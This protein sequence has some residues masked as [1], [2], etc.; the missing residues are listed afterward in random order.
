M[1]FHTLF[2]HSQNPELSQ[3]HSFIV[4]KP[5]IELENVDVVIDG[6]SI[7]QNASW[8]LHSG[9]NWAFVG[10]NGAGKSTLL[11]L[12][13]G[14]IWPL[15][16][17][18]SRIYRF[19]NIETSS[20]LRARENIA[21]VSGAQHDRYRR[22]EWKLVGREVV[23]SGFFNSELLHQKPT[24]AHIEQAES[25]S[26]QLAIESLLER[27]IS[28]L[29]HGE[30][31]KLLIA[32]ALVTRPKVLV[33]DEFCSGL[34]AASRAQ[35]LQFVQELA[36]LDIQLLMAT[37]R[38]DEIV[39]SITHVAKLDRGRIIAQGRKSDVLTGNKLRTPQI[40]YSIA[41]TGKQNRG[42]TLI[43]IENTDV[44]R[45]GAKVLHNLNW[46]WKSGEHWRVR[47]GNGGGKSTFL[48][49]LAGDLWPA[50]GGTIERFDNTQFAD[51]WQMKQRIGLV[52]PELQERYDDKVTGKEAVASGF[53]SSIG[54]MRQ[55]TKEQHR[56]VDDTI[57]HCGIGQLRDKFITQMS[58]GEARKLLLARALVNNP[59]LL[60]LDEP[61]DSLD[62]DSVLDF[63]MLLNQA[64]NRGTHLML[65]S[66]HD[67][68]ILPLFTR[69]LVFENGALHQSSSD[70]DVR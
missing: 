41:P 35:T 60:L 16:S 4:T 12:I 11:K 58:S 38:R 47:G 22:Q 2:T 34:D 59:D 56:A 17:K 49:L 21:L 31:R 25:L 9:E 15:H 1:S 3:T 39:S 30:L 43:R 46:T 19:D 55:L 63:K 10:G 27:D 48:K 53:F 61:F 57:E 28:A 70:H 64:A 68:D 32:R 40:E 62:A 52:S 42:Q 45:D 36:A 33:L 5:F 26:H 18:G 51:I 23:L 65:V 29:S 66:H 8:Q 50:F 44:F 67:E 37:H 13:R 7:L 6:Q 69:E 24:Q 54:V 14:D 20:P